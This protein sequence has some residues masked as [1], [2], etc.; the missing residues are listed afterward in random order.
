MTINEVKADRTYTRT[1]VEAR[2][3]GCRDSK[4]RIIGATVYRCD[5]F[6]TAKPE[7]AR[8]WYSAQPEWINVKRYGFTPSATRA[9]HGFG[10][11]QPMQHFATE[12]ERETAV[13]KY[14]AGAEKRAIKIK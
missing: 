7:D 14:F 9:G 1:N 4:G 5:V 12:A 10:A 2:D 6:Y 3:F 8:G 11:S 13:A